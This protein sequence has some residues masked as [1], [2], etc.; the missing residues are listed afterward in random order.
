[1]GGI[2]GVTAA[3][4]GAAMGA[5]ALAVVKI[6]TVLTLARTSTASCTRA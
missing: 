3:A 2:G 6:S 1:V 4:V 5:D